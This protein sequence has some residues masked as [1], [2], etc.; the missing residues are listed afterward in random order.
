ME[1]EGRLVEGKFVARLNRFLVKVRLDGEVECFLPNPGRLEELLVPGA[2]VILR[3][4]KR[5]RKTGYDLIGVRRDEGV[6]SIDSR[7]PNKLVREALENQAFEEF[8]GYEKIQ[9]EYSFGKSKFD[10]L[11]TDGEECL[12]E[13]KSCTLVREGVA[14][15]P[16]APTGRGRRHVEELIEAKKKGYRACVLFVVQRIDVRRFSPNDTMDPE[17]GE[18]LRRAAAE[19]V[20]VY[21][22]SSEFLGREIKIK[23]RV[24]VDL[25]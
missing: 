13:V 16:D 25:G 8:A 20:E 9:P 14:M 3:E 24:E 17:F 23:E 6:V 2:G 21:A 19:G 15:F 18:T 5:K 1:I 4:V 7:I 11:L 12:L 10:F 22:Y